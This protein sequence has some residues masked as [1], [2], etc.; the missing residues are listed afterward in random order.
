MCVWWY[1]ESALE[2]IRAPVQLEH[3][4]DGVPDGLGIRIPHSGAGG[5][6]RDKRP[7]NAGEVLMQRTVRMGY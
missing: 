6:T 5:A 2:W 1:A 7:L 3:E 4:E